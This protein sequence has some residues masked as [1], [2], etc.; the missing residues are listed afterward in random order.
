M[1]LYGQMA[2]MAAILAIASRHGIPVI[3]DACQAHGAEYDGQSRRQHGTVRLLQLL[4]GQE[5]RRLR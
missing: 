5:S 2:D 3:E 4:S 1:H